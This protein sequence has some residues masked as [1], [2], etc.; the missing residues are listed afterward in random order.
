MAD[1]TKREQRAAEMREA[2]A[3]DTD[4]RY[5]IFL[6]DFDPALRTPNLTLGQAIR[7]LQSR[8]GCTVF[9][10]RMAQGIGVGFRMPHDPSQIAPTAGSVRLNIVSRKTDNSEARKSWF[11]RAS[12]AVF[13]VFAVCPIR[14]SSDICEISEC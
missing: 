8:T 6:L 13:E 3:R 10:E 11:L 14:S 4:S 9:F 5:T 12:S 7:V 1:Y 2:F